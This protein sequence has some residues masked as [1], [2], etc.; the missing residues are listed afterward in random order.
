MTNDRLV[1]LL[2]YASG[3]GGVNLTCGAGPIEMQTSSY[4]KDVPGLQWDAMMQPAEIKEK[5]EDEI[6]RLCLTL[7]LKIEALVRQQKF[8]IVLGG[9]HTSAIGTWS[10][11]YAGL[12][13]K[14]RLGLI[15]I[16]A[17]MDSHVPETS[18]TGR[19]HGMPL[20]SLL[21][22]GNP[23]FTDMLIPV[24]K[25][26]PQQ[27]CLIGTRSYEAGEAELLRRLNVKVFFM[28]EVKQRGL[29]AVFKEAQ[30]IVSQGTA[31]YGISLDVDSIDPKEAPGVDV[32][33][34]DGLKFQDLIEVLT[35]ARQDTRLVGAEIVEFN[36]HRDVNKTTE[37]IVAKL[38]ATF[39]S[40]S[41]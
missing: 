15:W 35:G 30:E 34:Q 2:G 27:L 3:L 40:L 7:A 9:D 41:I 10:G 14:N 33:E 5:R 12:K 26:A 17:H 18:E 25:I 22:Y 38:I 21:G 20:A 23:Q 11:A 36:P 29:K 39:A 32:P 16:D 1:H 28:E 6:Q 37:K 13:E 24:P 8:F 19:V 31:G 4:L